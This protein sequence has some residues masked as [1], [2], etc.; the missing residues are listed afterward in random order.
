[1]EQ[2]L[3]GG[4]QSLN[5]PISES[6]EEDWQGLL[7]DERPNP[8]DVVIGMRDGRTRSRWLAE[9]LAELSP[10]E[11]TIINER[12]LREQGATL[13]ALGQ[14]LGVSKE[15]VRQ[16]EHRALGKLRQCLMRRVDVTADLVQDF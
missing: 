11:R 7:A 14:E 13:E 6:G 1:M 2:R 4:D 16:L 15:R 5:A 12:R 8:E 9:A 10:R 3:S